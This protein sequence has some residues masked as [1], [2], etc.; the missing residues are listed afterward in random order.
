MIFSPFRCLNRSARDRGLNVV[1]VV[2]FR[3]ASVRILNKLSLVVGSVVEVLFSSLCWRCLHGSKA[4]CSRSNLSLIFVSLDDEE[5]ELLDEVEVEEEDADD[6]EER[7]VETLT[8]T[9]G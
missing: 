9:F 3:G 8:L 2:V 1:V 6:V 7:D 4:D 5:L